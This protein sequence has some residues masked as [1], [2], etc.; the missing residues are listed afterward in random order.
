MLNLSAIFVCTGSE[1]RPNDG[2]MYAALPTRDLVYPFQSF[3]IHLLSLLCLNL[4]SFPGVAV[5]VRLVLQEQK[6]GGTST[7]RRHVDSSRRKG[8][9][10]ARGAL[11]V[12]ENTAFEIKLVPQ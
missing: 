1:V 12:D 9:R 8:E 3:S 2:D 7:A 4:L 11:N 10:G 5:P 6:R